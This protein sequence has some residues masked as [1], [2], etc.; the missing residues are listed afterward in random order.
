MGE[1]KRR[2]AEFFAKHPKCCFCGGERNAVEIDHQPPKIFFVKKSSPQKMR[3]PSCSICNRNSS[4][5][6]LI[7]SFLARLADPTNEHYDDDDAE[8]MTQAM[9]ENYPEFIPFDCSSR[10]KRRFIRANGAKKT[11][12]ETLDDFPLMEV[13]EKFFRVADLSIAKIALAL[14]YRH[15]KVIA[16]AGSEIMC[17]LE[18]NV[19]ITD[20]VKSLKITDKL[21]GFEFPVTA[22]NK[23]NG[24]FIYRY[25]CNEEENFWVF[26]IKFNNSFLATAVI[27]PSGMISTRENNRL[28]VTEDG[29]PWGNLDVITS[30]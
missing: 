17:G 3:F 27:F 15:T 21:K 10:A 9:Y 1:R 2:R 16:P 20:P 5:H 7:F 28:I 26:S 6:D 4:G 11:L 8:K 18:G 24:Q 25:G 30:A 13:P 29:F 14:F 23:S 12:G 19:T 22:Y